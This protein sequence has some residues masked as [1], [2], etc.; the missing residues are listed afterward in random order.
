ML[1][2]K[3]FEVKFK[4]ILLLILGLISIQMTSVGYADEMNFSI[5]HTNDMHGRMQFDVR[6]K[7]I[8]LAKLK[9]LKDE[10]NPTLML[11]AGDSVQGLPISNNSLG[12]DMAEGMTMIP[13]DVT[14]AG[15]HEFDFGYEQAMKLKS[16]TP[17]VSANVYKNN[18]QSFDPYKIIEKEGKKFAIIGLT[19]PETTTKTHPNNIIGVSFSDPIPV[20]EKYINE[21]KGQVDAFVF[22]THLGVDAT[23]PI[24][25][26]SRS[27][28][29]TL[30]SSYPL[31]K[32]VIID[33]H[34]H[35]ELPSGERYGNVLLAQT[36][37]YLNNIGEIKASY[38]DS[39]AKLEAKLIPFSEVENIPADE[40][41]ENYINQVAERF[42]KAMAEPVISDNPLLFEGRGEMVRTRETNLGNIIGDALYEYGQTG[43]SKKSDLAVMNGGG[44]RQ[45]INPGLV[46]RG[47]VLAVLPFGNTVSQ[48]EVTG[49]QL[50]EMFEHSL[51][52]KAI[53]DESNQVVLDEKGLPALD[54]NG[55]FLQ[56]SSSVRV[57]YDSNLQG[58]VPEEGTKGERVLKIEVLNKESQKFEAVQNDKIYYVTTNDFLAAGG[59]GYTMLGGARE[60]GPSMDQVFTD[61]LKSTTISEDRKNPFPYERIIPRKKEDLLA[62]EALELRREEVSKEINSLGNISDNQKTSYLEELSNLTDITS[63]DSLLAKA[64]AFD[65][66][67]QDENELIKYKKEVLEKIK[68]LAYL[69]ESNKTD[70]E[71]EITRAISKEQLTSIYN[72]AL[73]INLANYKDLQTDKI[74]NLKNLSQSEKEKFLKEI[75][76]AKS[77]EEVEEIY[78]KAQD[79]DKSATVSN[80][81]ISSSSEVKNTYEQSDNKGQTTSSKNTSNQYNN[82]SNNNLPAT[83]ENNASTLMV[84]GLLVLS[85]SGILIK[86]KI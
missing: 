50:Y 60:E 32:I 75:N 12:V 28:A 40:K 44:I 26:Q 15:N 77:L 4:K 31:E 71:K 48:I 66:K 49:Q 65:K 43:F 82:L 52:S 83:G 14:T 70:L 62:S 38:T 18:Q 79:L 20:A 67:I 57:F 19:T 16:Y 7:S 54:R 37:N 61:Y 85:V 33:G 1:S 63:I 42:D 17:M 30:S 3:I 11:D 8:G 76:L 22:L 45:T 81:S 5:L 68:S 56:V 80:T 51:R 55:G 27:L 24:Q 78:K 2:K 73:E 34:S 10:I 64:Q 21:L 6:N 46:T 86:K 39:G 35:T 84:V 41:V 74:K 72:K 9:T 58:E 25:W 23:T 53:L 59:D 13:Y 69:S 29:K 36:G 47:D